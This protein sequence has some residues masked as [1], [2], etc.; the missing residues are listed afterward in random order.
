M[1]QTVTLIQGDWIGP[2]V[3]AVI[4]RLLAAAGAKSIGMFNPAA[5]KA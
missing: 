3:S 2:E 5:S 1:S 4:Q